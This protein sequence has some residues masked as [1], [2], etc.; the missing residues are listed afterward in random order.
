VLCQQVNYNIAAFQHAKSW[1]NEAEGTIIAGGPVTLMQP[2]RHDVDR[3]ASGDVVTGSSTQHNLALPPIL[4][5]AASAA[6]LQRKISRWL[7]T[8]PGFRLEPT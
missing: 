5:T 4:P 3:L 6:N 7:H 1:R 2:F 8:I